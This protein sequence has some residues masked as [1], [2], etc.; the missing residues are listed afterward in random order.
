MISSS[1]ATF[2]IEPSSHTMPPICKVEYESGFEV[3]VVS[4]KDQIAR[5]S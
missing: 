1:P 3:T 4:K 5:V 2:Q